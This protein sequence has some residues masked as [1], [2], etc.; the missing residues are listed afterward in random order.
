ME[1]YLDALDNPMDNRTRF[2]VYS[3]LGHTYL[4]LA[5]VDKLMRM[6]RRCAAVRA[7]TE[8]LAFPEGGHD[9]ARVA[10]SAGETL[11]EDGFFHRARAMFGLVIEYDKH[12]TKLTAQAHQRLGLT[13]SSVGSASTRGIG[14][15]RQSLEKTNV[16]SAS[17]LPL[18]VASQQ[19]TSRRRLIASTTSLLR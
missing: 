15:R 7:W 3:N 5:K 12:R 9:R 4:S 16:A 18:V 1:S 8:A 14:L 11:L 6:Q 19:T 13:A 10:F 17:S 2:V